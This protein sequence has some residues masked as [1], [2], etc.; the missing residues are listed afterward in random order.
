MGVPCRACAQGLLTYMLLYRH[1]GAARYAVRVRGS[2][3]VDHFWGGGAKPAQRV[4]QAVDAP[5]AAPWLA[6]SF[7]GLE[8]TCAFHGYVSAALDSGTA[9]AA[10]R[11]HKDGQGHE[12]EPGASPCRALFT[13]ARQLWASRMDQMNDTLWPHCT[14]S[15]RQCRAAGAHSVP[16]AAVFHV[17]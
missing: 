4:Q 3:A 13:R 5:A 7:V 15:S 12:G 17:F 6:R 11:P 16:G 1:P 2:H 8:H 14:F 9:V 10:S